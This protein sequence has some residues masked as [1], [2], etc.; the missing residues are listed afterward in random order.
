[1][2]ITHDYTVSIVQGQVTATM[3]GVQVF[4]GIITPPPG[5]LS[6]Y[7]RFYWWLLSKTPSSATC[8]PRFRCLQINADRSRRIRYAIISTFHDFVARRRFRPLARRTSYSGDAAAAYHWV[9][10]MPVPVRC[11]CFGMNG[12]GFLARGTFVVPGL[13]SSISAPRTRQRTSGRT[14][15]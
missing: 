8:Q 2:P 11:G 12:G 13:L 5:R 3:D 4:S 9:R 15:L 1:M 14:I 7:H 6:L 10:P